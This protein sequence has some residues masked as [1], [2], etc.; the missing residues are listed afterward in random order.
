MVILNSENNF[1]YYSS[2]EY[3]LVMSFTTEVKQLNTEMKSGQCAVK[4]QVLPKQKSGLCPGSWEGTSTRGVPPFGHTGRRV[5][6]GHTLNTW[7]HIITRKSHNV[8][9]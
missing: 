9:S 7:Q 4:N 1:R 8:L 6:L 3:L 5:V 2:A